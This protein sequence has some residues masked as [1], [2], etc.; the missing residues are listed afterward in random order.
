MVI[1]FLLELHVLFFHFH[2]TYI[3]SNNCKIPANSGCPKSYLLVFFRFGTIILLSLNCSF[4]FA[5][6]INS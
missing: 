2:K 5:I 3:L 6:I 1:Y 4:Y